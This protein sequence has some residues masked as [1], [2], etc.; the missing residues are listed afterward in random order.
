MVNAGFD[1]GADLVVLT[2]TGGAKFGDAGNV[3]TKTHT[4]R[5]MDAARH[6]GGDQ[7]T[8]V[9]VFHDALALVIARDVATIADGQVL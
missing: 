1:I 4:A 6:V 7:R 9:L 5:A 3:L 2:A 8:D